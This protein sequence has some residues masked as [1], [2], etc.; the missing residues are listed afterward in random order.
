[1]IPQSVFDQLNY[2]IKAE[3]LSSRLYLAMAQWFDFKGYT[4]AAK[5]WHKYAHEE[6]EH[7]GWVYSYL[8]D[9]GLLPLVQELEAPPVDF[10]SFA[11][12]V[13]QTYDHEYMITQECNQL[14]G[15]CAQENDW[16]TMPLALKFMSEQ[17]EE[18]GK[19]TLLKDKLAIYGE[20]PVSLRLFDA[21]LEK[22]A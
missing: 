15:L 7:A 2:R 14:A 4:G 5:L 3:E 18:M 9:L 13:L 22:M 21:E 6:M 1:M 19:V 20:D 8:Q 12:I 10:A 11:E 17:R 16:L